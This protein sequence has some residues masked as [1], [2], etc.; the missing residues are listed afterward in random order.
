MII[1]F[2]PCIFQNDD[3]EIKDAL[4]KILL[5]LMQND[6]HF[7]DARNIN[8]IFYNEN[9]EYV[10]D[11][12]P[13]SEY[14]APNYKRGLKEI[15][16]KKS[17]ENITSLHRKHLIHIVVGIDENNKEIHP[18][19]MFKIITERS[20]IIVENGINDWKFIQ[21]ICQKYSGAKTTR[22]T[23]YQLIDRAMKTGI[24][25][26]EHCGGIGEMMRVTKRWIEDDR[27]ENIFRYKLMAIFDS[28][29]GNSS[30]LTR[31]VNLVNYLKDK[32][33]FDISDCNCES[34]DRITWHIL[35]KK[36]IENYIPLNIM[37]ANIPLISQEL[38]NNLFS[39]TN[40]ELDFIKYDSNNIGIGQ[41]EIK[42]CFPKMFLSNFSYR[43]FETI[44]EHHK[45]FLPEAN[46]LIS[47]IEQILLKMAKI[48]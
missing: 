41:S 14:L 16:K 45:V 2:N 22:K 15:L 38:K 12:N 1:S 34:T 19:I 28:D 17:L 36:R 8:S 44:C 24:I 9:G 13:V 27:Y 3:D 25:E 21:G 5:L 47:E 37:F 32:E 48:L 35:Y 30:E 46:E 7:L 33:I 42:E 26:A 6:I 40:E 31:H 29:R 43:D 11:S 4:A 23:I 39:K 10:F 18:K 20:K